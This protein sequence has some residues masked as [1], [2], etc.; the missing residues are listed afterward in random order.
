MSNSTPATPRRVVVVVAFLATVY[1]DDS[2][3]PR[4]AGGARASRGRNPTSSAHCT[5]YRSE[6]LDLHG[7][8]IRPVDFVHYLYSNTRGGAPLPLRSRFQGLKFPRLV[9]ARRVVAA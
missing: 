4:R 6:D 8:Q 7:I 1:T 3:R 5:L 9:L 2:V